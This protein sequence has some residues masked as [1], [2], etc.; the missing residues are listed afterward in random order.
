MMDDL[1]KEMVI[2]ITGYLFTESSREKKKK[3]WMKSWRQ[4]EHKLYI[5]QQELEESNASVF[6]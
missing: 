2:I 5:L 4:S 6:F 3:V 1:Q